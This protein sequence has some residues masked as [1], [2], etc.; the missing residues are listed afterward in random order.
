MPVYLEID[1]GNLLV[2]RLLI[3]TLAR[4]VALRP[5]ADGG[6]ELVLHPSHARHWLAGDHP[7]R[8]ALAG[9]LQAAQ[10]S[11]EIMAITKDFDGTLVDVRAFRPSPDGPDLPLPGLPGVPRASNG[12]I[13]CAVSATCSPGCGSGAGGPGGGAG[14]GGASPRRGH[15]SCS[16]P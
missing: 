13:P 8:E 7:D 5:G 2:T 12:V 10:R 3:P 14:G 11:G 4:V 1:P 6:L 15:S 9:A 16:M